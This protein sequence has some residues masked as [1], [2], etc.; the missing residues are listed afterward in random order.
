MTYLCA[1]T[2][3][4]KNQEIKLLLRLNLFKLL[5]SLKGT[6]IYFHLQITAIRL[7]I[8]IQ[9]RLQVL[10]KWN[11]LKELKRPKSLEE[12]PFLQRIFL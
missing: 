8:V 6:F 12:K 5:Y 11:E 3:V 4:C 9:D 1:E 2:A 7:Q 10:Q